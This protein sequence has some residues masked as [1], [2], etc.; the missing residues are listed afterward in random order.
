MSKK[1][2]KELLKESIVGEFDTSKTVDVQGPM[3]NAILS[4]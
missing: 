4:Y 2:Y 1:S 3:L